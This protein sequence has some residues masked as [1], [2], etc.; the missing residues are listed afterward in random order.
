MEVIH[1]TFERVPKGVNGA[2][3]IQGTMF[4]GWILYWFNLF[5]F[6]KTQVFCLF[7]LI[8]SIF[9]FVLYFKLVLSVK[10]KLV[11]MSNEQVN[12]VSY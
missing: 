12:L 8:G 10:D 7:G 9:D 3:T 1:D 6:G 5:S 11:L 2:V 4:S